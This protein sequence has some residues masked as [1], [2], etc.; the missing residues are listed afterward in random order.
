MTS[1]DPGGTGHPGAG[2]RHSDAFLGQPLGTRGDRPADRNGAGP[3]RQRDARRGGLLVVQRADG[4]HN[5]RYGLGDG[6]G[7]RLGHG[8]RDGGG[9]RG[10]AAV[11]VSVPDEASPDRAAL[12]ALYEAAGGRSWEPR[13][14][15]ERLPARRMARRRGGHGGAGGLA[16]VSR[17]L[18]GALAARIGMARDLVASGAGVAAVQVAGRWASPQMPSYY[19][20]AELAGD[21]AVARFYGEE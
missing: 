12:V 3:E 20:R 5:G 10:I 16:E 21:G 19:A 18:L 6:R 2:D 1:G 14:L 15:G 8:R 13:Q 17:P 4:C 7:Q 11:T 9:A